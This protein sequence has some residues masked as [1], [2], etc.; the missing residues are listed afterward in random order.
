MLVLSVGS[1]TSVPPPRLSLGSLSSSRCVA[2]SDPE[3]LPRAY[4]HHGLEVGRDLVAARREGRTVSLS[5][6]KHRRSAFRAV[7]TEAGYSNLD[8]CCGKLRK[9]SVELNSQTYGTFATSAAMKLCP[10]GVTRWGQVFRSDS[11]HYLLPDELEIFDELGV[12]TIF[13]LRRAK[14]L[15]EFPGPPP[16]INLP[17][18]SRTVSETDPSSLIERIDGERWLFE[19]YCGMLENAHVEFGALFARLANPKCLPAVFHCFGGKDR[20][21]MTAALLLSALGVERE[22]ILDD[23]EQT[24][25][26][27]GFVH[28]PNVVDDFMSFG[29]ARPA[30]ERMLSAPRW[31]MTDALEVM[32][33]EHGGIESYLRDQCGLS[34]DTLSDLRAVL[35]SLL[36]AI[37]QRSSYWDQPLARCLLFRGFSVGPHAC[38]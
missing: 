9:C 37:L 27:R 32:D 8:C 10:K 23:Y 15:E 25:E 7:V 20:T 6:R 17:L 3:E 13:D 16:V 19:D 31:A 5:R 35:V 18:P 12:R 30:A 24:N 29:I 28:L 11:L 2:M 14:E 22:T 38:L 1:R 36:L 33:V 4:S 34:D 26:Y 21:G